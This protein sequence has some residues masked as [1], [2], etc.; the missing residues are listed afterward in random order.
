[1][2]SCG[3]HETTYN[4]IMKCDVDIRKDLY[5]KTVLSGREIVR[6]I[7]EKLCYVAL[8]FEQEMAARGHHTIGKEIVD[9]VWDRIRKLTEQCSGLQDFLIFHSF[10]GEN[11]SGFTS[12]E[13]VSFDLTIFFGL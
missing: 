12:L 13:H 9:L 1:M 5:A 6:D 10:R 3:I 11:G 8:D 2:E 4:S 7:R